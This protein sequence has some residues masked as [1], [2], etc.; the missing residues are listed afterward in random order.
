[1]KICSGLSQLFSDGYQPDVLCH[2]QEEFE[3]SKTPRKKLAHMLVIR[4]LESLNG[5]EAFGS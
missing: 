2:F 1:M 4:I 3:F 5:E